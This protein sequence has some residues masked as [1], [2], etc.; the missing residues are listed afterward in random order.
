MSVSL[1]RRKY[2]GLDLRP[3][4]MRLVTMQRRGKNRLVTGGRVLGLPEGL[5]RAAIREPNIGDLDAF[6]ER[7]RELVSPLAGT[8]ER[9]SVS[10]PDAAGRQLLTEVETP[11]KSHREGIDILRWQLK[12]NLPA[13]PQDV[14]IDYQVLGQQENGR[15]RVLVA[16]ALRSV[17]EQYEEAFDRA[18]YQAVVLDFHGANLY[19]WY[20]FASDLGEEIVLIDIEGGSFGFRYLVDGR[21]AFV[22]GRETAPAPDLMF[23]EM[24]RSMTGARESHP[25]IA[26]ARIF[27]HTDWR[28]P[29]LLV[30]AASSV[31]EKE[32]HLLN[33]RFDRHAA[34]ELNL[35]PWRIRSLAAAAGA[36]ERMI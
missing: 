11:F 35:P 25:E 27:L 7:L 3:E 12:A 28:E 15:Y 33:P 6:A 36:A 29:D 23:Q 17:V 32:I 9:I 31:F 10:L 20:R 5:L 21:V 2:L 24:N 30:E 22:R 19:N 16:L 1:L 4:E 34:G 8:E 18:G 26:R 13:A 14:Q